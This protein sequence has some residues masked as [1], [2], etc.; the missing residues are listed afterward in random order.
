VAPLPSELKSNVKDTAPA[1][2]E[3]LAPNTQSAITNGT[4]NNLFVIITPSTDPWGR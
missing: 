2:A 4:V 3:R 1:D